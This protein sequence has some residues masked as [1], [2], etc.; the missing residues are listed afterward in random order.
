[1]YVKT[2]AYP[3]I[4]LISDLYIHSKGLTYMSRGCAAIYLTRYITLCICENVSVPAN[5]ISVYM[6]TD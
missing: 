4:Y 5:F 2:R 1:M 3:S 6:G